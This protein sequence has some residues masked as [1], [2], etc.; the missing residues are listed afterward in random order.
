[1]N[2][3]QTI[4]EHYLRNWKT[5][6]ELCPFNGGPIHELP[7]GF[8]V[9]AFPPHAGRSLWTYATCGMSLPQDEQRTELHIFSPRADDGIVELLHAV[10]HFHRTGAR[11]D[12]WHTVNF[13]RPWLESSRCTFGLISLPYL[14]GPPVENLETANGIVKN[15]WLVPITQAELDFKKSAGIEALETH[16]EKA[17]FD[18]SDPLRASVV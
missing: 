11:L 6:P 18:Y 14:D 10:A 13:G 15:Y 3:T 17:C 5:S 16:F 7:T 2:W 1:M 12:L 8:K 9:L 4:E